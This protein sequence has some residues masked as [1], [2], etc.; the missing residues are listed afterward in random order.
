[1]EAEL[2]QRAARNRRGWVNKIA[3]GEAQHRMRVLRVIRDGGAS[4]YAP[5]VSSYG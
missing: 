1:M 2:Y 4:E 3:A 5:G